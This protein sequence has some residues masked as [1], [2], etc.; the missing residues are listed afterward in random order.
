MDGDDEELSACYRAHAPAVRSYLR[1][2]VP[3][4]D[5]EDML[6]IVFA[7]VW[8]SRERYDPARSQAAWVFAIAHRRAVDHLRA[9]RPPTVPLE[10][11]GDLARRGRSVP[12]ELGDR[13][14]IDRALAE[15]PDAQ[16]EAIELA[17]F[18]DLTQRE[19]AHRLRVPIGTVKARISRGL[20]R[21]SA[22]LSGTA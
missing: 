6:Q 16:R 22:L 20:H 12:D 17:Y 15:L 18:A 14:Q 7:D 1:R 9:R 8:R 4:Q 3:A 13:D 2:F 19:I 11:A 10:E 21:L 5:V